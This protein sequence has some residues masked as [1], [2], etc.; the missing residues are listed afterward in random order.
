MCQMSIISS[1]VVSY[2]HKRWQCECDKRSFTFFVNVTH[3]L[4]ENVNIYMSIYVSV[5]QLHKSSQSGIYSNV[6]YGHTSS[7]VTYKVRFNEYLQTHYNTKTSKMKP[8]NN[9][10]WSL[11]ATLYKI[12]DGKHTHSKNDLNNN[13]ITIKM[14]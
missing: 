5:S 1:K 6:K 14:R 7:V 4:Y 9:K 10:S 13:T 8:I 2:W 12:R 11:T 3:L